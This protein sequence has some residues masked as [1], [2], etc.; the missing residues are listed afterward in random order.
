MS[1]VPALQAILSSFQ[2]TQRKLILLHIS[3][4]YARDDISM[5]GHPA[6][7]H[8]FRNYWRTGLDRSR[9]TVVPLGYT[10]GR[11]W[12]AAA[13]TQIPYSERKTT[14][15]FVG[16]MDRPGREQALQALR[17]GELPYVCRTKASW[18]DPAVQE[19]EA[20]CM[21]LADSK[22][23][24]CMRGSVALESFRVYE[25]IE[26]GA[27]PVFVPSESHGCTDEFREMYGAHPFLAVPSWSEA[28]TVM[29]RL[30]GAA[31]VMEDHRQKVQAWWRTTKS[32]VIQKIREV[33][34]GAREPTVPL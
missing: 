26:H 23:V 27:I 16:S 2:Q 25:A 11:A 31:D 6:V 3:D 12:Q 14:W 17:A 18:G 28:V 20:Y 30:E 5:Y 7:A 19:G 32:T 21:T 34:F 15:S 24:P 29:K 10:T 9:V 22:F 33:V 4:E 1:M 8:V 13:H